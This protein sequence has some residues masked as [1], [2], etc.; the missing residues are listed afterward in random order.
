MYR[1]LGQKEPLHYD[2]DCM[3]YSPDL[4]VMDFMH[5][6]PSIYDMDIDLPQE[7]PKS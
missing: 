2:R 1:H 3:V 4:V 6:F 5:L 7:E